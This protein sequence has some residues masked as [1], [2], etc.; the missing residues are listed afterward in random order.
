M[1]LQ[2][3]DHVCTGGMT[4]RKHTKCLNH[5]AARLIGFANDGA[6]GNGW[7]R[8]QC[9]FDFRA[10]DVVACRH[11]HVIRPGMVKKVTILVLRDRV[12]REIPAP[13]NIV[14]LAFVAQIATTRGAAHRQLTGLSARQF[15]AMRVHH[16]GFVTGHH[17]AQAARFESPCW[18]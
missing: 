18:R 16:T 4:R 8:Q 13:L 11:N 15:I 9:A 1:V 7:V 5:H 12:T 10:A 14:S 3:L 17:F 6:L 2:R